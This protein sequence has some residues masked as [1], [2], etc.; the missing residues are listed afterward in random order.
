MVPLLPA[1]SV[2]VLSALLPHGPSDAYAS[3]GERDV[4]TSLIAL[5]VN[6]A[7]EHAAPAPLGEEDLPWCVSADDP[8]CAP[9]HSDAGRLGSDT[10]TGFTASQ[11]HDDAALA[12]GPSSETRTPRSGLAP[13]PGISHRIER[14]PRLASFS[15]A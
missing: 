5:S 15:A 1:L 9:L 13:R 14:P 4:A 11:A 10:S 2:V 12:R 8:R 7:A 6:V 3:A